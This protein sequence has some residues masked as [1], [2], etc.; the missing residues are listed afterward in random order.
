MLEMVLGEVVGSRRLYLAAKPSHMGV[1]VDGL[2][3]PCTVLLPA[4]VRLEHGV[5]SM[6]LFFFTWSP[7]FA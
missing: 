4:G 1:D 6:G 2:S 3:C 7:S 5:L